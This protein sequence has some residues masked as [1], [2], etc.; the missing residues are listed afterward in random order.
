[1]TRLE[2]MRTDVELTDTL[3]IHVFQ[4]FA[5]IKF[6]ALSESVVGLEKKINSTCERIECIYS[7]TY[8]TVLANKG[9]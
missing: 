9:N 8:F 3:C 5:R 2:R 4:F 7:Y 1:M 6:L